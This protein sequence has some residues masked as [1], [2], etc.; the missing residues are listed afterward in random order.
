MFDAIAAVQLNGGP[1][2][3]FSLPQGKKNLLFKWN[4]HCTTSPEPFVGNGEREMDQIGGVCISNCKGRRDAV[5]S[6]RE[7]F[8]FKGLVKKKR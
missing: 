4:K 7:M 8:C 5:E 1:Q 3:H 6:P 2:S